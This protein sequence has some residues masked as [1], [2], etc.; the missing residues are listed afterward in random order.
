MTFAELL[1]TALAGTLNQAPALD[2]VTAAQDLSP[3]LRML[4]A[5][6]LEG[7]R[8]LAGRPLL[9]DLP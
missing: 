2:G 4:R 8:W 5:A 6:S 1:D 9:I 7:L 3:E